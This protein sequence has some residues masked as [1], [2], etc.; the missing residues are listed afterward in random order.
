MG[1]AAYALG[2]LIFIDVWQETPYMALLILAGLV[3][4]PKD[5][6]EAALI[7]G[8]NAFQRFSRITLPLMKPTIVVAVLLR[9]IGALKTL[10]SGV[11]RYKGRSGRQYG[12]YGLQHL[13]AGLSV[14]KYWTSGGHVVYS[15]DNY[16]GHQHFFCSLKQRK[17]LIKQQFCA[18][19]AAVA[20]RK[21]QTLWED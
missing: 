6:Y 19:S 17:G 14:P 11:C 7:E 1:D 20:A 15:F 5:P 18:F 10:R 13:Q 21:K 9:T 4:L 3:S 12:G 2:T 16:L 8:A